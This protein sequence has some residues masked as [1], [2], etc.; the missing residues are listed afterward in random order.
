M[1]KSES[2]IGPNGLKVRIEASECSDVNIDRKRR[3]EVVVPQT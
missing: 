2:K 3:C 1:R